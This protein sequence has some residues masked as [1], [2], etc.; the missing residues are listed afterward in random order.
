MSLV[1]QTHNRESGKDVYIKKP[2]N[3]LRLEGS[4]E[5]EGSEKQVAF[6][7]QS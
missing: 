5:G 1:F 7:T 3:I 4:G 6:V 2:D